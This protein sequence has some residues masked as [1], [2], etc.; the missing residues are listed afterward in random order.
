M[1][2]MTLLNKQSLQHYITTTSATT[3]CI[4]VERLGRDT[5]GNVSLGFDLWHLT[6][7]Q[8][9][10][11]DWGLVGLPAAFDAIANNLDK[12]DYVLRCFGALFRAAVRSDPPWLWQ[13]I[14]A[15]PRGV[16]ALSPHIGSIEWAEA[17]E[18][19]RS[20]FAKLGWRESPGALGWRDWIEAARVAGE[21]LA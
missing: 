17:A 1:T 20:D 7:T 9:V 4:S 10:L 13:I 2:L 6:P 21:L 8:Q 16:L 14:D 15:D 12:P 11:L 19:W 3:Q 18:P 5:S